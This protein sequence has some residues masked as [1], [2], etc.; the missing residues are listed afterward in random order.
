MGITHGNHT[1]FH[2]TK[3]HKLELKSFWNWADVQTENPT[4][5]ILEICLL[6]IWSSEPVLQWI[7][8]VD[9]F[10]KYQGNIFRTSSDSNLFISVWDFLKISFNSFSK[11]VNFLTDSYGFLQ[12]GVQMK[13]LHD[14]W[15]SCSL[16]ALIDSSGNAE[17][18]PILSIH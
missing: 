15:C 13:C 7:F 17:K 11:L 3:V 2:K 1:G 8:I 5:I 16:D 4:K 9:T 14:C 6:S 12:D 18:T 10:L